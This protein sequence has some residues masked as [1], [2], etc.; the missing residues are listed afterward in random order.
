MSGVW[1]TAQRE[2]V[3]QARSKGFLI[4][5]GVMVLLAFLGP[6]VLGFLAGRE[7]AGQDSKVAVVGELPADALA[8]FEI[9]QVADEAAAEALVRSGEVEAALVP[10]PAALT[11]GVK[12]VALDEAPGDLLAAL[13]AVPP[14]ELLNPPK[15]DQMLVR[16]AAFVFA[17]LFFMIVMMYGQA[18]A[19]NTVVEKQ[20]RVIEILLA[21]V[22]ARVLLAGKVISGAV[23][24]FASVAAMVVALVAGLL[25]GGSMD[26][27][28]QAVD[29][30][31]LGLG[32]SGAAGM[33]GLL[34]PALG[35]FLALFLVAFVMFSALMAASAATVSRIED[36]SAVLTPV[37]MVLMVPYILV[38]TAPDNVVL[39]N[40]LSYIPFSAPTAMPLR[41]IQGAAAWWEPAVALAL[42]VAT[43][44][45]AVLVAGRIYENTIL[46]TGART[47]LKEA[48]RRAS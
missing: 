22:P 14:V 41:L 33:F 6:A 15:V 11:A 19:T 37:M 30:V 21:V 23:L 45:L 16:G 10:Q 34:G 38:M 4:G 39:I 7:D 13:T 1:L 27:L 17:I 42:L 18:V 24:A 44:W 3:T 47:K 32:Q 25:V 29:L 48:W 40:W 26:A 43:T 31:A 20:T 35:W 8:G 28:A 46:R 9:R 36:A 5:T 12:V 2:L